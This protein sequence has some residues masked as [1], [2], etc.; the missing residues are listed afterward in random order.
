M[1]PFMNRNLSGYIV[2]TNTDVPEVD[3]V[4]VGDSDEE[5]S[6]LGAKGLGEVAAALVAPA[7]ANAVHQATGKRVRGLPITVDKLLKG[8]PTRRLMCPWLWMR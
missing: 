3:V 6:L 4:F 2:P 1:A 8:R 7:I 5:A